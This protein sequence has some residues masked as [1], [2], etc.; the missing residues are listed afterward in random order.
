M[1]IPRQQRTGRVKST[2]LVE[3]PDVCERRSIT[4]S[5]KQSP[6][7]SPASRRMIIVISSTQSLR[8]FEHRLQQQLRRYLHRVPPGIWRPLQLSESMTSYVP[9]VCHL[10][11]SV[12][13]TPF[14]R[15][16]SRNVR[17]P[18]LRSSR[19]YS[20]CRSLVMTSRR[21][22]NTPL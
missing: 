1:L 20:I 18:L 3:T 4:S 16:S 9:S 8:V 10:Q 5:A 11:N 21:L 2:K 6:V 14:Q 12:P 13:L 19:A 7:L 15:G 22:G 17:P